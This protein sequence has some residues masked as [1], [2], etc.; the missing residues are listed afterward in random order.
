MNLLKKIQ[1]E[2]TD[3]ERLYAGHLL[4]D[5]IWIEERATEYKIMVKDLYKRGRFWIWFCE[6]FDGPKTRFERYNK[7]M[8]SDKYK[9]LGRRRQH[10]AEDGRCYDYFAP[11]I[12]SPVHQ[13]HEDKS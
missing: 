13:K 7:L 8:T 9:L 11:T 2:M 3:R 4:R 1:A 12:Y 6:Y 5:P 10:I